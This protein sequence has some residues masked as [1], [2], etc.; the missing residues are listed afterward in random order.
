MDSVHSFSHVA[1]LMQVTFVLCDPHII[2]VQ[3]SFF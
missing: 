3:L 2:A 1:I